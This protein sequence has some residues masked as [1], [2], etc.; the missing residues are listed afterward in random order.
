L[1]GRVLNRP[2]GD[3][4]VWRTLEDLQTRR[5]HPDVAERPYHFEVVFHPYPSDGSP[6]AFLRMF[7]KGPGED[8]PHESPLP[9][10]PDLPSDV[11]GVIAGVSQALGGP[12]TT[13][14]LQKVIGDQLENRF[15]PGNLAPRVP[16]MVFGPT[17]LPPGNGASTEVI[18]TPATVRRALELLFGILRSEADQGRHLLGPVA[19]RFVPG[20]RSLLGMNQNPMNCFIELPS[21]R[22]AEVLGI[23][24]LWW[25]ALESA[26]IA[27]GGHWGQLHGMTPDRLARFY[28]DGGPRWK[29]ARDRLLASPE[30]RRVFS[31]HLLADVG[32][33]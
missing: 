20:T 23:Y 7:W 4:E 16:G 21:V 18:V 1:H 9:N 28:G 33:D 30:A 14:I 26:G 25:N 12:L 24:R 2:G 5:F 29:A 6:G 10:S 11:M 13:L 3:P 17:G 15:T 19:V 27:F 32:L 22:S 8:A 31:S